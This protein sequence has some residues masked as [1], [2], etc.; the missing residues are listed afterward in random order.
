[1]RTRTRSRGCGLRIA[2]SRLGMARRA[3]V[4]QRVFADRLLELETG[5]DGEATKTTTN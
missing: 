4:L 2:E 3:W 1:M 5:G